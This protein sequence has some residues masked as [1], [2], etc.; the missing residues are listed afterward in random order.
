[1]LRSVFVIWQYS[2]EIITFAQNGTAQGFV[3]VQ[4]MPHSPCSSTTLVPGHIVTNEHGFCNYFLFHFRVVFDVCAAAD[5][6]GKWGMRIGSTFAVR[7][8]K[9][10]RN[11]I[12]SICLGFE[13]LTCV[14]IQ[15]NMIHI[16]NPFHISS[17]NAYYRNTVDAAGI[18]YSLSLQRTSVLSNG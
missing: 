9:T 7:H 12:G 17:S 10:E 5:L 16:Y 14:L 8:L 4:D 3:K 6:E 11:L 15:T 1:M 2:S 18:C 13:R